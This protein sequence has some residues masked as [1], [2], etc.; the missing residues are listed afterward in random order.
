M[1]DTLPVSHPPTIINAYLK[2]KIGGYF[3]GADDYDLV[4]FPTGPTNIDDL[5]ENFP[6]A[7]DNVFVVYDRMFRLRREA[8]PHIKKEQVLY[9]FY[10]KANAMKELIETT[11]LVQDLLDRGDESA[12]EINEWTRQ[13]WITQGQR[14]SVKNNIVTGQPETFDVVSFSNE[15]FLLPYFH[16]L[17]IFQLEEARDIIDF[18]TART[19]AGNKLI[20]N[21]DWH[22][23]A[24]K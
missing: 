11:Q 7:V 20:V 5:T 15:D 21:Y 2:D 8:F 24:S 17:K 19:W 6:D 14:T 3:A 13:L 22:H 16:E 1:V 18:G 12:Q 4:F 10:K 9:Y 23:P